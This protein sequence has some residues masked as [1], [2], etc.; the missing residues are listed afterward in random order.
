MHRWRLDNCPVRRVFYIELARC[1][2]SLR[3]APPNLPEGVRS[4]G[5]ITRWRSHGQPFHR[6]IAWLLSWSRLLADIFVTLFP[7][8]NCSTGR[9]D[10]IP[11]SIHYREL[12]TRLTIF[13][14]H[15]VYGLRP[16]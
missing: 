2:K 3:L 14:S 12:F 5:Y 13:F 15:I 9:A 4:T 16:E 11:E 7:G 1:P 6:V 10:K 8:A